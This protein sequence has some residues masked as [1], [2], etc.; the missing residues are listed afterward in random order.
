MRLMTVGFRFEHCLHCKKETMQ[1][2]E[3]HLLH[4]VVRC[5]TCNRQLL[6]EFVFGTT[7]LSRK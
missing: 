2:A 5:E 7:T 3:R 6:S 4:R 1:W